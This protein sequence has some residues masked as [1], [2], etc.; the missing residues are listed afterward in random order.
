MRLV[1]EAQKAEAAK[2]EDGEKSREGGGGGGREEAKEG[3]V[4]GAKCKLL[5][6]AI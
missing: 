2:K 5:V 1:S 6:K 3:C 4:H